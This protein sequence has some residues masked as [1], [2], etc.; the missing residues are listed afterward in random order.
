MSLGTKDNGND[1]PLTAGHIHKVDVLA[2]ILF[3]LFGHSLTR[4]E[5]LLIS[6]ANT[7]NVCTE[8]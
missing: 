3:V 5:R 4:P 6:E 7:E 1:L 2:S 8:G